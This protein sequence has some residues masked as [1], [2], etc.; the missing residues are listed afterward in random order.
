MAACMSLELVERESVKRDFGLS[1]CRWV[2]RMGCGVPDGATAMWKAESECK[3]VVL[4]CA[5]AGEFSSS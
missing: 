2:H 4:C 5:R 3:N 1:A